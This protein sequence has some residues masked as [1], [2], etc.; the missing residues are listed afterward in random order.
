MTMLA[1]AALAFAAAAF[2][3]SDEDYLHLSTKVFLDED[4]SD[5]GTDFNR[6]RHIP[7][8]D[9]W[10]D[11]M[12]RRMLRILPRDSVLQNK[13]AREDFLATVYYESIRAGL[14]PRWVLALIQ[15]ESAFR[16]Y[17]ISNVG[18]QGYMQVM[19]FWTELI[20]E[21]NHN[22]FHLRTNLRY[23]TVI[24]RHYLEIEDGDLFRALGRY[25]GSVG[26]RTYPYQVLR[27]Y[28]RNWAKAPA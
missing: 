13:E 5:L 10:I 17:A 15:V 4:R 1:V 26:K 22:L 16:K 19:P 25:N 2:A 11:D 3:E 21:E 23:G 9:A 28:T 14:D 24:L 27:A 18:A 6:R 20:G 12:G 7:S 8:L